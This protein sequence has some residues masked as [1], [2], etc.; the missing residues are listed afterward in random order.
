MTV[1]IDIALWHFGT[2][3]PPKLADRLC[4][5]SPKLADRLCWDPPKL[6]ERKRESAK[7]QKVQGQKASERRCE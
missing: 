5:D 2:L 3:D 1:K 7:V 6:V 4:W